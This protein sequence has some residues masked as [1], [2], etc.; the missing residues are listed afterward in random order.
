MTPLPKAGPIRTETVADRTLSRTTATWSWIALRSSTLSGVL[1]SKTAGRGSV[2]A[3]SGGGLNSTFS[4]SW[5]EPAR[6]A[7][8]NTTP[9]KIARGQR[10]GE[11]LMAGP[12]GEEDA[13]NWVACLV[14][15]I[16]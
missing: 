16:A 5:A 8:L 12:L 9:I 4:P 10:K 14:I 13:R 1:L 3:L 7:R 11:D 6:M 15:Y 2:R